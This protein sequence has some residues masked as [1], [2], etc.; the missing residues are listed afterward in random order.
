MNAPYSAITAAS[1][2]NNA[3]DVPDLN[4]RI[5][6]IPDRRGDEFST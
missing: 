1:I 4:L 6:A 2:I 5:R 3:A